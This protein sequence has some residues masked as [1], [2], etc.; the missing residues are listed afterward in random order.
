MASAARARF[1]ERTS[2]PTTP[3]SPIRSAPSRPTPGYVV[4]LACR[5]PAPTPARQEPTPA[6]PTGPTPVPTMQAPTSRWTWS[7][8]TQPRLAR[9]LAI[10]DGRASMKHNPGFLALVNEARKQIRE[11][12]SADVKARLDRG[13]RFALVDVREESE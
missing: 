12:T 7:P 8:T 3:A 6:A 2:T 1:T 10:A 11:C 4:T 9:G 13:E 5:T